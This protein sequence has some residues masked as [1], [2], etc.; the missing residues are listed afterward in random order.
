MSILDGLYCIQKKDN[1]HELIGT[2][3]V[4]GNGNA[5]GI[6]NGNGNGLPE[7]LDQQLNVNNT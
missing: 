3:N 1:Q 4:L 2:D 7:S 5:I 6:L